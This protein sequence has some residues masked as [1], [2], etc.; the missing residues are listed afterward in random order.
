[1]ANT[2]EK[3]IRM[4]VKTGSHH[5]KKYFLLT[6]QMLQQRDK[7]LWKILDDQQFPNEGLNDVSVMY[8]LNSLSTANLCNGEKTVKIGE[9]ECRTFSGL[10]RNKYFGFDHGVGRSGNLNDAQPKSASNSLISKLTSHF[11][12]DLIRNFGIKGCNDVAILPYATGMSLSTCLLCFKRWRKG[13][14]YVIISRMDHKTC[15][16]CVDFCNLKYFVV[17][18]IFEDEEL[19]T[20]VKKIEELIKEYGEKICGVMTATSIYAPRNCDNMLKVSQ[21]CKKYD[22]PHL[23]NNAFGLQCTF[24]CKEIQKCY[25]CEGR[26]DFVVQSCDKN[27]LVPVGG[28]IVFSCDKKKIEQL[29]KSYPGR[30]P[31]SAYLDLFITLLQL[32]KNEILRMRREREAN[33]NWLIEKTKLICAKYN[34]E[35]IKTS[36]NKLSIAVNL[37]ELYKYTGMKNPKIIQLIGSMLFYRNVT[38]HRVIC[39]PLLLH[40]SLM[41]RAQQIVLTNSQKQEK[42]FNNIHN[43]HEQNVKEEE[44]KTSNV[45]VNVTAIYEKMNASNTVIIGENTFPNFG[46]SCSVY[47]FSYIAFSCV[48]G[49]KREELE[50]FLQKFDNV[51]ADFIKRFTQKEKTQKDITQKEKKENE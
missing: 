33:Y 50:Q 30:A 20:D 26:I 48:I 8:I 4:D 38:G 45:D 24:L 31:I 10:V 42:E 15:Y 22:I 9:R 13:S 17:D 49:M 32:G 3:S 47:P 11:L 28:G 34:L 25:E 35:L 7:T 41:K 29:K 1:M 40:I 39:S 36:R 46:P 2:F 12:K 14:E 44:I 16:K 23:V 51:L 37:N 6:K 21:I 27:F 43:S 5:E 18:H 19:T